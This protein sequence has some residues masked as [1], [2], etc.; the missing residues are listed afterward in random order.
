MPLGPIVEPEHA[1]LAHAL[2]DKV[3]VALGE[4]LRDRLRDGQQIL[5]R[6]PAVIDAPEL[7]A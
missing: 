2:P 5:L 1:P 3:E 7:Q 6:G 4:E